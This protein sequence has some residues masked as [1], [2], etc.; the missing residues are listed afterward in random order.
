MHFRFR[1]NNIQVVKSQKT[2]DG[3]KAKSMPMGSIN[4]QTL[5]ISDKLRSNSSAAELQ[6]I[7]AWVKRYQTIDGIKRKHAALTLPEQMAAAAE[8]FAQ[9][10]P[11]EARQIADDIMTT[12]VALR[13]V[14][15][16]RGLI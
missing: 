13:R 11:D 15:N 1:G 14:L 3:G 5:S 2:A 4:R 6:E 16:R 7:E 12:S 9:A 8:W 10:N